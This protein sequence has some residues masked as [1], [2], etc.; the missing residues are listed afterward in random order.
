MGCLVS[1]CDDRYTHIRERMDYIRQIENNMIILYDLQTIYKLILDNEAYQ[2]DN[3]NIWKDYKPFLEERIE[4]VKTRIRTRERRIAA[5]EDSY[6]LKELADADTKS[7]VGLRLHDKDIEIIKI[8]NRMTNQQINEH[9]HLFESKVDN[10]IDI[11]KEVPDNPEVRLDILPQ[12]LKQKRQDDDTAMT[13][14]IPA[15]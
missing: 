9:N 1:Q 15:M 5:L 7:S 6:D 3:K 2:P 11:F 8:T 12:Q 4:K 13:K 10:D 14:P